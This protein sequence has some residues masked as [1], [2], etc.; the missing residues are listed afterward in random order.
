MDQYEQYFG[1]E[2]E[3]VEFENEEVVVGAVAPQPVKT[4]M[5]VVVGPIAGSPESSS[6]SPLPPT[7]SPPV[8]SPPQGSPVGNAT[9]FVGFYTHDDIVELE[10][11]AVDARATRGDPTSCIESLM[12]LPI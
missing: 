8:P 1:E 2:E 3:E 6:L 9:S 11:W 5:E 4:P 10:Q 12:Y 7:P